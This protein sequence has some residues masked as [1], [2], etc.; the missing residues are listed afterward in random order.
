MTY[1]F[2][3][4]PR[5]N[6]VLRPLTRLG[7]SLGLALAGAS[8]HA[9]SRI[10]KLAPPE[11]VLEYQSSIFKDVGVVQRI[12]MQ[13]GERFLLSTNFSADFSD[14][15]YTNYV[16]QV[17]PGYAINDF[18]E[19][20]LTSGPLFISNPRS[21]VSKIESLTLANN[22]R[23]TIEYNKPKFMMGFEVIWA[24]LYGKDALGFRHL[25]RSD[26]FLKAGYSKVFYTGESGS[27][28]HLGFGKTY[29]ITKALGFRA[30]LVANYTQT[31]IDQKKSYSFLGAVEVGTN[32]YF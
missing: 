2:T 7:V 25:V 9:A 27:R 26:T 6:D 16:V 5:F 30:A 20:Y 13:K 11:E 19:V 29:F 4:G 21:I 8:A 17:N 1:N 32:F 12:A 28:F 18:W 22:E 14:G 3:V 24:P 23:A 15:P 10:D 31:I